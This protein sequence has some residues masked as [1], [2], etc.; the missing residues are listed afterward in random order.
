MP[1]VPWSITGGDVDLKERVDTSS[2]GILLVALIATGLTALIASA[3][4][5]CASKSLMASRPG[6][7]RPTSSV[8]EKLSITEPQAL[9]HEQRLYQ[10]FP[11]HLPVMDDS[12]RQADGSNSY[13]KMEDSSSLPTHG[14]FTDLSA[15]DLSS[16]SRQ[17][18]STDSHP[19]AQ[20][21]TRAAAPRFMMPRPPPPPPLTP[22]ELSTSIFNMDHRKYSYTATSPEMGAFFDQPNPDYSSDSVVSQT[23]A[24]APSLS[25]STPRRRSYTKSVPIGVPA[26]TP[27]VS[28]TSEGSDALSTSFPPTIPFLPGPP[29]GHEVEFTDSP[30]EMD[31]QGEIISVLDDAGAGWKRH[32]RVYGGGVCLACAASG[33]EGH[34]GFYGVNV[35]PEDRR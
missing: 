32:T 15:G 24:T 1:A 31:V 34:G 29:P 4:I 6:S 35:R 11:G 21:L 22:P 33:S 20:R 7:H 27:S 12:L 2:C 9:T 14:S 8:S 25:P 16:S 28:L 30:H 13:L 17:S 18:G 19:P 5:R 26:L 3:A 10:H 23:T